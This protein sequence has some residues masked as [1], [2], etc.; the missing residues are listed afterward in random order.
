[1]ASDTTSPAPGVLHAAR[2]LRAALSDFEPGRCTGADCARVA[3]ELARTEKACSAGRLLAAARAVEAGAHKEKGFSDPVTWLARQGGTTGADARQ[4]L[5]LA[6]SLEDLAKTKEAL[7]SGAIS[8]AQANEIARAEEEV[9]GSEKALLEAARDGD[10]TTVRDEARQ[11]R[12]AARKPE[13]LHRAQL[14][15]RR[16]RHWQDELGMVRIEGALPPETGIPLVTRI[17]R[18]A[19]RRRGE[20][21]HVGDPEPFGAYAADALVCLCQDTTTGSG[22]K[23]KTDLVIVC[24]IY[25]WRRGHAHPGEVCHIVGGGPIPVS[26]AQ[27]LSGDAFLKCVL[28]DGKNIQV[29]SHHGRRCTAALRTAL[30]LGPVPRFSGRACVDCKRRFGLEYD[31]EDPVAHTGKTEIANM[32]DRCYPCHAEKTERD[33]KAGLLGARAKAR[34]G[35]PRRAGPGG[36]AS[37]ARAGARAPGGDPP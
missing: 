36:R 21:K 17:E 6:G 5:S 30:D 11:R 18:E 12:L 15:A 20:A 1:M 24:D 8:L 25:A 23:A 19:L 26:L 37:P 33:R 3:D 2:Q 7:F 34:E 10:L 16:F 9:P 31:H 13:D 22:S 4:A 29:V 27:E 32:K 14:A 35:P 28:H